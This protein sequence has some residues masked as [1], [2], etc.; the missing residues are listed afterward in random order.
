MSESHVRKVE[1]MGDDSK[2]WIEE[3]SQQFQS[4]FLRLLRTAHGEKQVHVNSFYQELIADKHHV[5]MTGTKWSSLTEFAKYLGREGICRVEDTEKGIHISWIDN[6]PEALRRREALRLREL[7]EQGDGELEQ[8]LIR[9]Q[10]RRARA[11]AEARAP[12]TV[13]NRADEEARELK[14]KEGDKISLSFALKPPATDSEP[15]PE[16]KETKPDDSAA[17]LHQGISRAKPSGGEDDV[18][19]APETPSGF[20]GLSFKKAGKPQTRNV[21]AEAE[22]EDEETIK[23]IPEVRKVSAA[24]RIMREEQERKRGRGPGTSTVGM[25]PGK[26]LKPDMERRR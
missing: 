19:R 12:A 15:S 13:D 24:E 14:R 17:S 8:R 21:F 4:D 1:L 2:A 6:S 5:H 20:G 3:T 11:A 9:E 16:S 26:R 7:Q 23:G 18:R 10:I 25:P 22:E